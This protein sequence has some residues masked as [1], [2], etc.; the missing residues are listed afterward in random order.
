MSNQLLT[1][2]PE[3]LHQALTF[4]DIDLSE[5]KFNVKSYKRA[6]LLEFMSDI[7]AKN[8]NVF[9]HI[10]VKC[11]NWVRLI[12]VYHD[13]NCVAYRFFLQGTTC[14]EPG[15]QLYQK[16]IFRD[17]LAKMLGQSVYQCTV[18]YP[19]TKWFMSL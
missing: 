9:T 7:L 16:L 10:F 19:H 5:K 8:P 1:P 13:S 2:L 11:G 17:Y 6:M 14:Y 4:D 18:D 15:D 12:I 3:T